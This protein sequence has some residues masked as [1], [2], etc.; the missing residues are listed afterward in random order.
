M[1]RFILNTAV[2]ALLTALLSG[3]V[4]TDADCDDR[5]RKDRRAAEITLERQVIP[6]LLAALT[7]EDRRQLGP[8]SATVTASLD[9]AR[10]ALEQDESKGSRLV[11]S[12]SFLALQDALVD[13]SVS[14]SATTGREQQL[15]DYS[16]M[17]ARFALGGPRA[18]HKQYPAPFWQ[19]IGWTAE[20]YEFFSSDARFDALRERAM[21]QSLAWLAASLLSERLYADVGVGETEIDSQQAANAIRQRTADLLLRA[22]IAPAPAWSVAILFTAIRHPHENAPD[23]WT[24]GARDVLDTAAFAT[25][26]RG[27]P[28]DDEL[29]SEFREAVLRRWRDVSQM[30][31][32]RATCD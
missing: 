10:I 18:D 25:E 11:I 24:C 9:P 21:M 14:A 30:L 32:H 29:S 26:N 1:L 7:P 16:V 12:T 28:T 23:P 15:V 3:C 2:A 5:V 6:R 4:V 19:Y 13:G 27:V 31:Q 17:V 22:R 8:V 20:R